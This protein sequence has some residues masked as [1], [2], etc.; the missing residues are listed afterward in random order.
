[1]HTDTAK[2]DGKQEEE[3]VQKYFSWAKVHGFRANK[4]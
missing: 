1:M 2:L 3:N 4:L